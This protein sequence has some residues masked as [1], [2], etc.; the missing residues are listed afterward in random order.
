MQATKAVAVS[1]VG[2]ATKAVAVAV[3]G[4]DGEGRERG[5]ASRRRERGGRGGRAKQS[6]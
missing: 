1:V 3:V 2:Q 6:G 4:L 5:D